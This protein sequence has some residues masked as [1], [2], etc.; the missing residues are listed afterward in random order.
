MDHKTSQVEAVVMSVN[1]QGR[2]R[3]VVSKITLNPSPKSALPAET[4]VTFTLSEYG[5][6]HVPRPGQI[7]LL[8]DIEKFS[9]G[10]RARS[11]KPIRA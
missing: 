6:D 4:I 11:A 9:K 10:W 1:G 5:G 8:C 3:Y 7:V 2:K